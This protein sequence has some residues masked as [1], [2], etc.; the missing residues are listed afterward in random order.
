MATRSIR[1]LMDGVTGRLGQNQHLIRSLLAIRNEGGLSLKNG[2]RLVPEP[3]LLGRNADK[4]AAL[5]S[6]HGGLPWSTDVEASLADPAVEIY[7]DVAVTA[8]RV[9]RAKR[10]I[11]AGKHIYLEKPIAG[12]AED[13]LELYRAANA[14]A[15]KHGVVQDKVF[16]PGF[17]KLRKVRDAGFF[18]RI[19]SVRLEFGWWVFDGD[20]YPSQRSSWNY[21][22]REGGGLILDM[23]PHWRYI[24]EGIVGNIEAVSCRKTTKIPRRRDERGEAYDVD[25]E[26]E[27]FAT[28]QIEGGIL[29]QVNSSWASRVRRDDMLTV[30]I[31]GTQGSAVTTLHRCFIQPLASTPKPPWNVDVLQGTDFD[32]QWQEVPDVDIYKNSY[33]CGWELFLRHVVEGAP[34]PSPLLAGA[35][36]VQ[37]AE[38]CYRSDAE[39]RWI[40]LPTLS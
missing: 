11:A 22:K 4:L 40:D 18:G 36:G 21:K 20:L 13:A 27:V 16:L 5:A 6:A 28:F 29:A 7:F 19:L 25:V 34:F 26:D 10:A 1:I 17:H 14:A 8:G 35:K 23:F 39:R 24:L 33:R 12:S 37:L 30:Q 2:E 15:V 32:A 3:V 38:A 31:D 9:E